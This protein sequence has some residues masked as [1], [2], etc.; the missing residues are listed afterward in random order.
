MS[1]T[2]LQSF[3]RSALISNLKVIRHVQAHLAS[4]R[5]G[6]QAFRYFVTFIDPRKI[7]YIYYE[8][9]HNSSITV[10]EI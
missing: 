5:A 2:S 8:Y 3:S 7:H 4:C 6:V 9:F 1:I 10:I